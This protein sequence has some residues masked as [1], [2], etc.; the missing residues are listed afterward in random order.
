MRTRIQ[1]V[2]KYL[3]FDRGNQLKIDLLTGED[4]F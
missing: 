4:E 1:F 3:T 2:V